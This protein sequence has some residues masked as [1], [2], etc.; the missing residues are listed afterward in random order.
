[1]MTHYL[2]EVDPQKKFLTTGY[3]SSP[4]AKRDTGSAAEDTQ[5][6]EWADWEIATMAKHMEE[7]QS[8]SIRTFDEGWAN[9]KWLPETHN[10]PK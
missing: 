1:M 4:N 2:D 8:T 5:S 9:S 10:L 7:H 3:V 6:R